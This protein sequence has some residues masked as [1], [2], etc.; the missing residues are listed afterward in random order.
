MKDERLLFIVTHH[1]LMMSRFLNQDHDYTIGVLMGEN[2]IFCAT[3]KC[4]TAPLK[5]ACCQRA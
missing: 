1:K 5:D 3:I 2:Y 4:A